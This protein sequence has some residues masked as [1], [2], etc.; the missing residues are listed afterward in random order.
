MAMSAGSRIGRTRAPAVG[1]RP[2]GTQVSGGGTFSG[3]S[4]TNFIM[5]GI[6]LQITPKANG[7]LLAIFCAYLTATATTANVGCILQIAWGTG[8][9][10]ANGAAAT[11]T[12]VGSSIEFTVGTTLTALADLRQ[13]IALQSTI[14]NLAVGVNYWVDI[15]IKAVTTVSVSV[16]NNPVLTVLEQ[17]GLQTVTTA[18]LPG[19]APTTQ[20]LTSGTGATYTTPAGAKW[21]EVF[22]VGGG[23]GGSG[24]SST[25]TTLTAGGT[26]GTSTFNSVN[27][28][29]GSGGAAV[30]GQQASFGGIGGTGGTG[31]ATRRSPGFPGAPGITSIT[32]AATGM[33]GGTYF[34][35]GATASSTQAATTV[36]A[37]GATNSGG[38]GAGAWNSTG[39]NA[40]GGGGGGEFVYLL[41]TSPA[42]T[43]TYTVGAAGTAGSSTT[44]GGAGGTGFIFV[45]EHYS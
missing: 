20:N 39:T 1:T 44:N 40:G 29:G 8:S 37:S 25:A 12:V 10:P 21:L 6:G 27:A 31:A 35:G 16:V 28:V 32:S 23:G 3:S 5:A 42:S 45:I 4:T 11:G 30:S 43:Y 38:G 26:G 22:M 9:A 15:Q 18:A 41:I 34:G 13:P 14:P 17:G 2:A 24:A 7:N 19:T 36:G 33:G